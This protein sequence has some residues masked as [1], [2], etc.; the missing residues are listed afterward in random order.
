[1]VRRNLICWLVLLAGALAGIMSTHGGEGSLSALDFGG[2]TYDFAKTADRLKVVREARSKNPIYLENAIPLSLDGTFAVSEGQ[3]GLYMFE[4]RT[5]DKAAWDSDKLRIELKLPPCVRLLDCNFTILAESRQE[6]LK[7]G[8][9]HWTLAVRSGMSRFQPQPVPTD[10]DASHQ[11]PFQLLLAAVAPRG[12]SGEGAI[13]VSNGGKR[14]SN[15]ERVRFEIIGPI[16]VTAPKRLWS[17]VFTGQC[18]F[19]FRDETA[20][21]K[22]AAF[23]VDA[24]MRWMIWPKWMSPEGC[25]ERALPILRRAGFTYLTPYD[26]SVSDGY[27]V[28]PG[29]MRPQNERFVTEAK[30]VWHDGAI[31]PIAVYN[32]MPYFRQYAENGLK[33]I[34]TGAD[35]LWA[36]W[37]PYPACAQ[38]CWCDKCRAAFVAYTGLASNVVAASW[39]QEMKKDGKYA[40]LYVDFRAKEFAKVVKAIDK[41]V[42]KYTGGEKSQG[43]NPGVAWCEMSTKLRGEVEAHAGHRY[44][45]EQSTREYSDSLAWIEPWGPYARWEMGKPYSRSKERYLNY[46]IAAK[47]VREQLDRDC[48]TGARPKLMGFPSGMQGDTWVSQPEELAMAFDAYY[49]NGWRAVVPYSFPRGYDARYWRAIAAATERAAKYEDFILDGMR[50]DGDVEVTTVPEFAAPCGLVT[51]Y[52][53]AA[54]TVSLLQTAVYRLKGATIV[55]AFNYWNCGSAFFDLRVAGLKDGRYAVVDE[56]GVRYA[57]NATSATWSA[58][59]LETTGVRLMVGA[60][61]TRVFEILPADG[62]GKDGVRATLTVSQLN[63]AYEVQRPKLAAEAKKDA[64]VEENRRQRRWVPEAI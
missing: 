20:F 57:K 14:V 51:P 43:F 46:F 9:T 21:S 63:A 35:G 1:M 5:T 4:W 36:N 48:G 18:A 6:K 56:A 27:Q 39:P 23:M 12:S 62:S 40:D 7:D 30:G 44:V 45:R 33:K 10:G 25:D 64:A 26:C 58:R 37:E 3:V 52:V 16:R 2:I 17:G 32:E 24:G 50:V 19:D 53:P 38:G 13:V 29:Y 31:C 42:R 8:G 60:V 22:L 55:A 54:T 41:W 49:F 15:V 59:E 47:D 61:R 28:G 11:A 34:L